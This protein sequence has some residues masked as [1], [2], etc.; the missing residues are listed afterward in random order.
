MMRM[1]RTLALGGLVVK[2]V[3]LGTLALAERPSRAVAEAG[4]S[5]DVKAAGVASELFEKS[6]GFRDLLEAARHRG[7]ELDARE[8]A[9][10][11][12]EA[13]LKSLEATVTAEIARLEKLGPTPPP[14]TAPAA[15]GS[16]ATADAAAGGRCDV[17]LT[18]IY[19]GMKPEEAAEILDRL[20]D[21]TAASVFV[22][23]KERQIGAIMAAMKP[24]RAVA[25]THALAGGAAQTSSRQ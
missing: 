4:P 17:A 16:P 6:R 2:G 3:L 12:R 1:L 13:A 8:Q 7:A 24:D 20:D 9:V 18:K 14:V 21:A 19:A 25:L 5:P 23:M 15:A 11:A 10:A 22:C